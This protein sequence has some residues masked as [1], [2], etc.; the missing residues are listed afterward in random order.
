MSVRRSHPMQMAGQVEGILNVAHLAHTG[1]TGKT[2]A[3][4]SF[5]IEN[6]EKRT[7]GPGTL[8]LIPEFNRYLLN[9]MFAN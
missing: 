2:K 3:L 8:F 5:A 7:G 4:L 6:A 1:K 9:Y